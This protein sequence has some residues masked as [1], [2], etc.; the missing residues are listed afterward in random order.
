MCSGMKD[1]A[2]VGCGFLVGLTLDEGKKGGASSADGACGC[3]R[4]G[5]GDCACAHV[6]ANARIKA[7]R[8]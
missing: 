8:W 1:D 2:L 6:A 5:D 7:K 4:V 3:R